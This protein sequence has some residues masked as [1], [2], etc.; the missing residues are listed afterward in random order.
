M[1]K[2]TRILRL[3]EMLITY[4]EFT[5]AEGAEAF[6]VSQRTVCRDLRLL[7]QAGVIRFR[8]SKRLGAF[9]PRNARLVPS[10]ADEEEL[11]PQGEFIQDPFL[12]PELPEGRTQRLYLE[13]IIRLCDLRRQ[14]MGEEDPIVWYR[15]RYPELSDRTRQRDFKAL[16]AAGWGVHYVSA[17]DSWDGLTGYWQYDCL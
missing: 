2:T 14:M 4:Q 8:W 3:F 16:D 1:E 13:K 9:I 6:G 17:R 15:E 12:P 7:S 11:I 10:P 5:L